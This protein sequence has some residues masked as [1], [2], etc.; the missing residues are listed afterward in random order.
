[1]PKSAVPQRE[2]LWP[3]YASK[4]EYL[5]ELKGLPPSALPHTCVRG[6]F[7]W[8]GWVGV[9]AQIDASSHYHRL[10]QRLQG[11]GKVEGDYWLG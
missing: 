9:W 10:A 5:F 1:M 11:Q 3:K 8:A 4:A 2:H 7:N 6:A